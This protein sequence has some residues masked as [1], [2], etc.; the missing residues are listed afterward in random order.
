ML[1]STRTTACR[2]VL[3]C[4]PEYCFNVFA[5]VSHHVD[6]FVT[7]DAACS[8]DDMVRVMLELRSKTI[9]GESVKARLKTA[10]TTISANAPVYSG[11]RNLTYKSNGV[12][13]KKKAMNHK[14]QTPP[15]FKDNKKIRRGAN[16]LHSPIKKKEPSTN[17]M[18]L[19]PLSQF[20]SLGED[21]CTKKESSASSNATTPPPLSQFPTLGEDDKLDGGSTTTTTSSTSLEPVIVGGYAAALL[22]PKPPTPPPAVKK[23]VTP[24]KVRCLIEGNGE[25]RV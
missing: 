4:T 17:S 16:M 15:A 7:L 9:E 21:P 3:C 8:R 5:H 20:P 13:N 24:E 6:R 1:V 12:V 10:S 23:V 19:P 22:K 2:N 18:T 25:Q 14:P 11:D